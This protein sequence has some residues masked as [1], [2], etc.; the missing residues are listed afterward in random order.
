[1]QDVAAVVC[2]AN[3]GSK[4]VRERVRC[5]VA[6]MLELGR[7]DLNGLAE[8]VHSTRRTLQRSLQSCG[9]SHK[10]I[11]DDVRREQA[12]Q[13]LAMNVGPTEIAERLQFSEPSAFYRAFRRWTGTSPHKFRAAR[14]T[15]SSAAAD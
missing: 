1:V 6:E 3:E 7:T 8:Y 10:E 15:L 4:T 2:E 5:A 13:L 12:L 11:L 9:T 14:P